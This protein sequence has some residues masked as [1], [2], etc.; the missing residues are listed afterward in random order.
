M[1]LV[2]NQKK[3]KGEKEAQMRRTAGDDAGCK[4]TKSKRIVARMQIN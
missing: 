4:P 2:V 1:W 3:K